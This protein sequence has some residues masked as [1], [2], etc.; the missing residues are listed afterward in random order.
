MNEKCRFSKTGWQGIVADVPEDWCLTTVSGDDKTGYFRIDSTSTLL[1]ETKWSKSVGKVDLHAKLE[2]YLED[3]KKKAK[4]KKQSFEYKIKS[5]D[6]ES[7]NFTWR[8]DRKAQG[9][10]WKCDQ[11][12]RIMIAQLSGAPGD[13]IANMASL[14]MPTYKD[15]SDDGWRIWGLYGLEAEVPPDYILE[16]H[17]LMS[18]YIQLIFRKQNDKIIIERWGL[19]N[20]VLRNNPLRDWYMERAIYDLKAYKFKMENILFEEE[21][22]LQ[23]T[24]NRSSIKEHFKSLHELAMFKKPSHKLDGYVWLCEETNKI[25]SIQTMHSKKENRINEILERIVCHQNE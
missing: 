14:I 16:K 7:L 8:S 4:K 22:G 18:G 17:K 5:K 9:R 2:A 15:H 23:I 21:Q 1:L 20:T 11:C 3:L 24:G 25:F 12:N 13:D 10:L 6:A 19:A